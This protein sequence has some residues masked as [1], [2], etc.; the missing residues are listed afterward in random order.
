MVCVRISVSIRMMLI[1][2]NSKLQITILLFRDRF[3]TTLNIIADALGAGII[4]HYYKK[5]NPNSIPEEMEL[6]TTTTH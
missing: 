1:T 4:A 6:Y 3:R 5:N 2:I